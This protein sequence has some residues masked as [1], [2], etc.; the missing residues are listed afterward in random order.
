MVEPTPDSCFLGFDNSELP[1]GFDFYQGKVRDIFDLNE[2]L[3]I[4]T[5]DRISAFAS[6]AAEALLILS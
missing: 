4:V 6:D 1:T 2:Q 5:S 3:L